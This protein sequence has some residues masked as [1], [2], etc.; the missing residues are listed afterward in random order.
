M[1]NLPEYILKNKKI[2]LCDSRKNTE[3]I[4]TDKDGNVSIVKYS[5]PK[6]FTGTDHLAYRESYTYGFS[7]RNLGGRVKHGQR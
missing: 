2:N 7:D 6:R 1:G 3:C 4:R 5:R